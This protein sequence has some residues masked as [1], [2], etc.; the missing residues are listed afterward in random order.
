[1][2]ERDMEL[3]IAY[4]RRLALMRGHTFTRRTYRKARKRAINAL[5]AELN[6]HHT[7]TKEQ[8]FAAWFGDTDSYSSLLRE[9]ERRTAAT[10]KHAMAIV[11]RARREKGMYQ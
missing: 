5:I 4:L 10:T 9:A 2:N 8:A 3:R 6:R 11:A 1:M 7:L